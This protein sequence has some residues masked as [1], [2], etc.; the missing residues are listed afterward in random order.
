MQPTNGNEFLQKYN[1]VV[2]HKEKKENK[3]VDVL[4]MSM[5]L[6]MTMKNETI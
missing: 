1:F 3:V 6:L 5:L 4:N 2:K